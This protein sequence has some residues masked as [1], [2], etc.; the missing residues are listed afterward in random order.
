MP[1]RRAAAHAGDAVAAGLALA[2]LPSGADAGDR[3]GRT[4]GGSAVVKMKPEAKLRTKSHSAGGGDVAADDA[5]GLGQRALDDGEAVAQRRRARQ[6]RR[7]A[8]PYSRRRAPRRDRSWRRGRRRRRRSRRSA[9]CRR[10]S[11]RR[12]R[13]RRASAAAG[14]CRRQLAG[15]I[16][17]SL[18]REDRRLGA[19][20]ADA[21]DHRGMVPRRTE[22]AA[23][24]REA[25][26]DR[27]AQFET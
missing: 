19:A 24:D 15:E 18:W 2:L 14:R 16:L 22:H 11:N 10:P 1:P 7:R 25:S 23:G 26:V 5:E 20:V 8:G 12:T 21:L 4:A 17:G 13:R 9:R 27:L 6:R 3:A